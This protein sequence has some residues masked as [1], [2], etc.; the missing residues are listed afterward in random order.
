MNIPDNQ[1]IIW[2][3][4]YWP[5]NPDE[6]FPV[7][8]DPKAFDAKIK[9]ITLGKDENGNEQ[10][11]IEFN[12]PVTKM[13]NTIFRPKDL[14]RKLKPSNENMEFE[15]DFTLCLPDTLVDY[16]PGTYENGTLSKY[17]FECLKKPHILFNGKYALEGGDIWV[18]DGKLK[19]WAETFL[20]DDFCDLDLHDVKI[21]SLPPYFLN[22]AERWNKSPM[23][24]SH[25][26][27]TLTLPDT[28]EE[29]GEY[30]LSHMDWLEEVKFPE[31]L[32]V[33]GAHALTDCGYQYHITLSLPNVEEI[34]EGALSANPSLT[35][36]VGDKLKK[37]GEGA[38][39]NAKNV[40][41]EGSKEFVKEDGSLVSQDTLI[42]IPIRFKGTYT[43]PD[44]IT[45]IGNCAGH[46]T[47]GITKVVCNSTV[48]SIGK[49]AFCASHMETIELPDTLTEIDDEA[50]STSRLTT[51]AIPTKVTEL[52]EGVF[53]YCNC[54]QSVVILGELSVFHHS[55]YVTKDD[56]YKD[57]VFELTIHTQTPPAFVSDIA[58]MKEEEGKKRL[59]GEKEK[60]YADR[61]SLS[62]IV[63]PRASV[64]AYKSADGWKDY[65]DNIVAG[66]F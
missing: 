64:D 46:C 4:G 22:I 32:K 18:V 19:F 23:V 25:W 11:V 54:L 36:K 30:A 17:A 56:N 39:L 27:A 41:F 60:E 57:S 66:D 24:K 29:I 62:K 55:F 12:K 40:T 20:F 63:V 52:R 10:T 15:G 37:I 14:N 48:R 58:Q 44:G 31:T 6:H 53:T 26:K 13:S 50:F 21:K 28:L 45:R 42:H 65:A 2:A 7:T 59:I 5:S 34:G 3:Y 33:I 47:F 16:L 61:L 51:V 38:F 1:I 35:L 49:E 9:S 8:V 43:V